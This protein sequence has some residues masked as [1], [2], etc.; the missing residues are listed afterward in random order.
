MLFRLAIG[1]GYAG[2]AGPDIVPSAYVSYVSTTDQTNHA[3]LS[4]QNPSSIG[5]N[6]PADLWI[7]D[8][9]L[10]L[11]QRIEVT[12]EN[13]GDSSAVVLALILKFYMMNTPT[14]SSIHI[15]VASVPFQPVAVQRSPPRGFLITVAIPIRVTSLLSNDANPGNDVGTRV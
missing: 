14:L 15:E 9:M 8:G 1:A 2:Q 5:M 3:V 4:S 13:Q 6:R 7:I 11:E 10:G 12:L